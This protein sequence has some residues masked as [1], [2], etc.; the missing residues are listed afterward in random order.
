MTLDQWQAKTTAFDRTWREFTDIQGTHKR[1]ERTTTSGA[2]KAKK[3]EP[4]DLGEPMDVDARRTTWEPRA[5][6]MR[7]TDAEKTEHMKSGKCFN[8][9]SQSHVSRDCPKKNRARV[10]NRATRTAT[11]TSSTASEDKDAVIASL[12]DKIAMM[13][14]LMKEKEDF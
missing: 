13:E 4:L 11:P 10:D 14:K 9:H 2:V 7:M 1:P 5:A 6:Y 12:M 8:C 3:E